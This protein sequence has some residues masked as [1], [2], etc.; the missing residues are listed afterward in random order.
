M[1][2][3]Q[4]DFIKLIQDKTK[5][6]EDIYNEMLKNHNDLYHTRR[7]LRENRSWRNA[8]YQG[9]IGENDFIVAEASP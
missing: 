7:I 8:V 9:T 2:S 3:P 6:A 5:S 1:N 4:K